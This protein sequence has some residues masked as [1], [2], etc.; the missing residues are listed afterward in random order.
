MEINWKKDAALFIIGQALSHFGSI[1]VQY[2]ILWHIT[3]TTQSGTM[4][5]LFTIVLFF[6]MFFIS[7]FAGVWADRY[8][9]KYI[10]NIAD[11]AIAFASLVVAILLIMGYTNYWILLICAF[12]RSLGYG[13]Q[14]P[15][16][17]ALIPI[18]VPK[19]HLTK[20]NGIQSSIQSLGNLTAPMISGV[21]MTL[22]PLQTLFFLDVVTAAIGISILF[23]L[24]KVPAIEI[25]GE[26][27]KPKYFG[28]L[29]EGLKYIR[30]QGYILRMIIIAAIFQIFLSPTNLLT[31]L[32]VARK[33]GDDV[34]RLTAIEVT[35]SIGMMVGGILIGVWGGFKN[36]VFTMA[37]ACFL[38][39][40]VAIGLGVTPNFW[41]Y[42]GIMAIAGLL[43]PLFNT[44][45]VVMLQS[46]VDP[47]FMGR[48]FSVF[49][50]ISSVMMP[51]GM[52][53]FGPLA[54]NISIDYILIGTGIAIALLAIPFVTS[55]VLREA[56]KIT[57]P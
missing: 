27:K 47:A 53:I 15:A 37:F 2:A 17:S 30:Q 55:K 26:Q 52:L 43:M 32:Q 54:D 46:K 14:M 34:W 29:R 36:R 38:F 10:I 45:A 16:V 19:E 8:N 9:R 12:T 3:L 22:A 20:I 7:P 6:P 42:I 51:A 50:M 44:T 25:Q 39:G 11:G 57:S 49:G 18:I 28:E 35:S 41:F 4:M 31:P 23:F 40:S 21:L 1:V 48:V 33:F 56:G 24:V 13:T 5:T